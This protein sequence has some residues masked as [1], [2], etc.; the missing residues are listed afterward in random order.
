MI[1]IREFRADISNELYEASAA[2]SLL[3]NENIRSFSSI[4]MLRDLI[5][6]NIE[7][8]SKKKSEK[9]NYNI[10]KNQIILLISMFIM[11]GINLLTLYLR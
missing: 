10:Q 1:D 3:K 5:E 9:I 6:E 2:Y 4:Q 11:T 7:T 8:N